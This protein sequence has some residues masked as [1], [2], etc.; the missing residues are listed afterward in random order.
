[1][2][3]QATQGRSTPPA[4]PPPHVSLLLT[5]FTTDMLLYIEC[6]SLFL[7]CSS[8]A[9]YFALFAP[10]VV[11]SEKCFRYRKYMSHKS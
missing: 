4:A 10:S 8:D 7:L 1:M 11:F 9:Q 2:I 6:T 3:I 5:N